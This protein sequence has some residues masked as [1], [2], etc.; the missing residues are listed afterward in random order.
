MIFFGGLS[1]VINVLILLV[2]LVWR[3]FP[4]KDLLPQLGNNYQFDALT[5]LFAIVISVSLSFVILASS[6]A[7]LELLF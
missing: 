6:F 3:V 5:T 2:S 7:M 4:R 1:L